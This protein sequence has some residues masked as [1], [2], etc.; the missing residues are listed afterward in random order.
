MLQLTSATD[1][2]IPLHGRSQGQGKAGELICIFQMT[3][4]LDSIIKVNRSIHESKI[5]GQGTFSVIKC[6]QMYLSL[7]LSVF[8]F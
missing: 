3:P 7:L 8:S 5:V 2:K 6:L 1:F 4:E